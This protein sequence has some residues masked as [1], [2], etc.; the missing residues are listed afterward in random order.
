[1]SDDI[2]DR[3]IKRTDDVMY[4]QQE[5]RAQALQARR[6]VAIPGAQW[7]GP[8]GVQ[9]DKSIKVEINKT[10]R[11]LKKIVNDYL[12][13]RIIPTFRNV[14]SDADEHTA[15]TIGGIHRAD[16]YR[17]KSQQAR[18]NAFREAAAGGFGA[19]RLLTDLDD[20]YDIDNDSQ[21]I[22]PASIIVDAD[23]SVYFDPNSKLYDKSDAQWASVLTGLSPDAFKADYPKANIASWPV[24]IWKPYYDWYLP[25]R[26]TIC[27]YYEKM[28][29]DDTLLIFTQKIS[30]VE[31]RLWVSDIEA[32][33]RASLKAQGYSSREQKRKRCRIKKWVLSGAEILKE[34]R[35]IAG[36]EIPVIPVYGNREY[37]DGLERF[38]GHVQQAMDPQRVY[39][40]R[41][42]KLSETSALA[43][44]EVPI[45]T[46][47]QMP[48]AI[49]AHWAN[50]N[51]E[52]HAYALALPVYNLDGT[53]AVMGPI[54]KIEPPQLPPVEAALIQ[55]MANDIAELTNADD[56]ADDVKSN[57]SAE[58]MELAATRTDAKSY[59][60]I[61][62][63]RQSCQREGEVFEAM[64]ADIY[65]EEG[66]E[67]ETMEEDDS[68]GTAIIKEPYTTNGG[69]YKIRND[70]AKGRY[71]CIADVTEATSTL[72]DK[73]V[74]TMIN[75]AEVQVNAQDVQGA[76]ASIITA[77]ANM[78][79]EGL[80]EYKEW[81]RKRGLALGLFKPTPEEEQQ[82]AQSQQQQQPSPQDMAVQSI[83]DLNAAK[84]QE[85]KASAIVKLADAHLKNSQ[86]SV[87]GGPESAPEVPSGLTHRAGVADIMSKLAG[88][89]LKAAQAAHLRQK[90]DHDAH[91]VVTRRMV[92]TKDRAA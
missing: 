37:I 18:D 57:T 55:I 44:R 51:I 14:G 7:E 48:P 8:W 33:D 78:D 21:R 80:T 81:N 88:A 92:A 84:A 61:D 63:M 91:D 29:V 89:D 75:V 1:M 71:K 39:N 67:V 70:F 42:S 53:I 9:F 79:G 17:F 23:Q 43:P 73:T 15:E 32:D 3:A 12:A 45:F 24:S 27:E 82:A 28:D 20:P 4:N 31:V 30:G 46:P 87:L 86:A 83:A 47:D 90:V 77:V 49:A 35:F 10:A 40:A 36:T 76:Q 2:L 22:N 69:V 50:M 68:D 11:G 58:A 5:I 64:L 6:F 38:T 60:Y 74:R 66:R 62:N 13:N 19:Y 16:S 56:G 34:G 52:R 72:R 85:S 41:I 65:H 59:Q 54:G 26:I 25:H